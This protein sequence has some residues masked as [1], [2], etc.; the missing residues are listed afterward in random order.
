MLRIPR[1]ERV[2]NEEIVSTRKHVNRKGLIFMRDIM[3]KKGLAN[4]KITGH[5]EKTREM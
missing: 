3:K 5:S 1:I 2:K 4:L